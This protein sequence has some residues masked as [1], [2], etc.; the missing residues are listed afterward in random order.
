M[1]KEQE[2]KMASDQDQERARSHQGVD[3]LPLSEM[4]T[5]AEAA[6]LLKVGTKRVHALIADETLASRW[7]TIE[8]EARLML[9]HRIISLPGVHPAG[10]RIKLVPKNEVLVRVAKPPQ[11]GRPK[12]DFPLD[13]SHLT[14]HEGDGAGNGNREREER[15]L[16]SKND[17]GQMSC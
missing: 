12:R 11:K 14:R 7:A 2:E 17:R 5:V 6:Q 3:R 9:D 13:E 15:L 16:L 1:Q 8:E 4:L 10:E